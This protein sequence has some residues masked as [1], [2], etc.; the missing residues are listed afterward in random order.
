MY[1]SQLV[2]NVERPQ[3]LRE[4]GDAHRLHQR[5]MQGFP[6]Q[7]GRDRPRRDWQVLFRYEPDRDVV[8]VQSGL[9]PDWSRLP[10]GYLL[11]DGDRPLVKPVPLTLAQLAV[12]QGFQF[13][14]RGNPSRRDNATRKVLGL[15]H[16]S[17]QLAWLER[18]GVRHGF[19]L[20]GADVVP[21]ANV[22]G[23][24]REGGDGEAP[25]PVRTVRLATALFQGALRVTDPVAFW[26]ALQGGIGR[27][28]SYGCGLL[29]LARLRV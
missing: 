8:L 19:A 27:G 1:L 18:Q 20:L 29:S 26:G 16:R 14:L 13:R 6:D 17:D 25:G 23:R 5:I 9:E 24:K 12:G 11:L 22:F 3:V 2:L 7:E 4:L 21:S 10:S 15:Y 28:K